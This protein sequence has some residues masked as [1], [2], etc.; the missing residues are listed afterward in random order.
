MAGWKLSKSGGFTLLEVMVAVSIIAIV[1]VSEQMTHLKDSVNFI[2]RCKRS[3][4]LHSGIGE[5]NLGSSIVEPLLPV[6]I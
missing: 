2:F 1:F 4:K 5:N 6:L 3:L